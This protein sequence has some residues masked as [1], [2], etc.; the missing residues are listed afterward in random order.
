MSMKGILTA[1][2]S[3]LNEARLRSET[4][5]IT[6]LLGLFVLLCIVAILRWAVPNPWQGEA[7]QLA[8]LVLLFMAIF[9]AAM[10]YQVRRAVRLGKVIPRGLWIIT[11]VVESVLPAAILLIIIDFTVLSPYLMLLS[12]FILLY[13]LLTI[14]STLHL[15]PLLSRLSG[16][17]GGIS[18]IA[19]LLHVQAEHDH[20]TADLAFIHPAPMYW[21]AAFLIILGGFLAAFVA[22]QLHVHVHAAL[23]EQEMRQA[24]E[25][26]ERDL[27]I[28]RSIQQGLLPD[29]A[30]NLEG[31]TIAGWSRPAD[32]T[33][34]D[35][36]DWLTLEDGRF[37]FSLADVTGHGIGPAI[38][39]AVCRAYARASV[40]PDREVHDVITRINQMLHEDTPVDRFITFVLGQLD[41][42]RH[43]L[44]MLSAGHGPILLYEAAGNRVRYIEAQ[45]I[46]LGMLDDYEFEPPVELDFQPG[47]TLVLVSDGFFEWAIEGGEQYGVERL[48]AAILESAHMPPAE[49][50]E[51][52]E[53]S[54]AGFVGSTPQPDDMTAVILQR[55]RA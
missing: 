22:R 44:H 53:Q 3:S 31:F 18:Y 17:I 48:E 7:P 55:D 41:P 34:G 35:Y 39:T 27:D 4:L 9:E 40:N 20:D 43:C 28:A 23:L 21:F 16:I 32:Q 5:R 11:V 2:S 26:M 46:P 36:Y 24:K 30:P 52:L 13:F 19:L 42:A 33:G 6:G 29:D 47:D 38:V 1:R 54:I 49:I 8:L 10:L 50:I 25:Q 14:L 15:D 12:P 45:G 37:V 51:Y